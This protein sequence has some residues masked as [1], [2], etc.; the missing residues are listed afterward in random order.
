MKVSVEC[1]DDSLVLEAPLQDVTVVRRSEADLGSMDCAHPAF[2]KKRRGAGRN[3]L[4]EEEF[5][6][7]VG[8]STVSS[9]NMAAA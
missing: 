2:T 9:A 4:I 8:T 6:D 5:H 1:D 7:I 3:S